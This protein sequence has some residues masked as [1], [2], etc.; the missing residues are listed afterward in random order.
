MG[1]YAIISYLDDVSAFK[2]LLYCRGIGRRFSESLTE[3][4]RVCGT[5]IIIRRLPLNR[6]KGRSGCV[7]KFLADLLEENY[8]AVFI[9]SALRGNEEVYRI[10]SE[11][12]VLCSGEAVLEHYYCEIFNKFLFINNKIPEEAEAVIMADDPLRAYNLITR[13]SRSVK[14]VYLCVN[15][16]KSFEMLVNDIYDELGF[17]VYLSESIS[18][19]LKPGRIYV[20]LARNT[21]F[22]INEIMNENV[23]MLNLSGVCGNSGTFLNTACFGISTEFKDMIRYTKYFDQEFLEFIITAVNNNFNER[24]MKQFI[25][26]Y[27]VKFKKICLKNY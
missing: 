17:Y 5:D 7:N 6:T 21:D 10:L 9:S 27:K 16:K 24:V 8:S 19:F 15:N 22:F 12:L 4:A 25:S 20:N 2:Q 1:K 13:I 3:A 26:D 11:K 18:E 23:S 14:N